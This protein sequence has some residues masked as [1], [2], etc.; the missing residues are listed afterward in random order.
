MILLD[1][2]YSDFIIWGSPDYPGG[3]AYD[4]SNPDSID[5]TPYLAA[6]MNDINGFFQALILEAHGNMGVISGKPD[7]ALDSDRLRALFTVIENI[8]GRVPTITEGP[9]I[10]D[11][12][13]TRRYQVFFIG[14]IEENARIFLPDISDKASVDVVE[15][16]VF[17]LSM[18]DLRVVI[19]PESELL[20]LPPG[21][22]VKIRPFNMTPTVSRWGHSF[23]YVDKIIPGAPVRYDNGGR[24]KSSRPVIDEDVLRLGDRDIY[25]Q[26]VDF[27]PIY[28]LINSN[29]ARI[30]ALENAA[31]NNIFENPFIIMFTDLNGIE[32]ISGVWN[33]PLGRLECSYAGGGIN[34]FF[35]NL[36]NVEVIS[37]VWNVTQTRLE[38]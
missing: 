6:W 9:F 16:E 37:G 11:I 7:T 31:A 2:N 27:T 24:L 33:R 17:N 30:E 12:E 13:Q 19:F 26:A 4:A 3:K 5:G 14:A 28:K 1:Q 23:H 15:I 10:V 29:T 8:F 21:G 32:L 38:C 22:W 20:T 18:Q 35:T 36:D 25:A 34:I